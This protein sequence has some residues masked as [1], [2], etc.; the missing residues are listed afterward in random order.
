M[1][2]NGLS[3]IESTTTIINNSNNNNSLTVN[4]AKAQNKSKGK[5][6]VLQSTTNVSTNSNKSSPKAELNQ[7]SNSHHDSPASNLKTNNIEQ[8]KFS[9]AQTDWQDSSD[10]SFLQVEHEIEI[11][12]ELANNTNNNESFN[13]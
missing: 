7:Q 13:R 5:S 6:T 10:G 3:Q 1:N 9:Q 8:K 11:K 4:K 12:T 2:E